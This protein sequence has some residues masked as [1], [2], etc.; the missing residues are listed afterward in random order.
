MWPL[1]LMTKPVPVWVPVLPDLGLREPFGASAFAAAA[2][3]AADA[4]GAVNS[5]ALLIPP[6]FIVLTQLEIAPSSGP[7]EVRLKFNAVAPETAT[8]R[9]AF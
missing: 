6:T 5:P 4:L 1:A 8:I 7:V 2:S 3:F 9:L